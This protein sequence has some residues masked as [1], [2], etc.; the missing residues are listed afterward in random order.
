MN[1]S[2]IKFF[3]EYTK[4]IPHTGSIQSTKLT[5]Q[6]RFIKLQVPHIDGASIYED[7]GGYFYATN[8]DCSKF[9]GINLEIR[10][11]D[12]DS[13]LYHGGMWSGKFSLPQDF[14]DRIFK[15]EN[16]IGP[17]LA[18]IKPSEFYGEEGKHKELIDIICSIYPVLPLENGILYKLD[19]SVEVDVGLPIKTKYKA[20]TKAIVNFIQRHFV[21]DKEVLSFQKS[22]EQALDECFMLIK[23]LFIETKEKKIYVIDESS[24]E[25]AI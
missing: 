20:S 2:D 17:K 15:K 13:L 4:N 9:S 12:A 5:N 22:A 10:M 6:E 14:F 25:T 21:A 19:V 24:Y 18:S 16:K 3:N 7:Y 8:F 11:S 1:D 23:E